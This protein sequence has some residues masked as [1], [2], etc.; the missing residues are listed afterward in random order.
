MMEAKDLYPKI[1]D[2][3]INCDA[4]FHNIF[5]HKALEENTLF[6]AWSGH[7]PNVSHLRVLGSKAWGR[8]HSEKRKDL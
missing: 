6:E 3:A 8:I 1:W 2:E 5:Q 7:K 4:Y